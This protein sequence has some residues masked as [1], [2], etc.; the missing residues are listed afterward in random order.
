MS[1]KR[2]AA[3]LTAL[4]RENAKLKKELAALRGEDP[5]RKPPVATSADEAYVTA[6]L[7]GREHIISYEREGFEENTGSELATCLSE[8]I[9]DGRDFELTLKG[10]K[11]LDLEKTFRE[12]GI[13]PNSFVYARYT[14]PPLRWN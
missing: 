3:S 13:E 5:D 7:E 1:K 11:K 4:E 8:A 9:R 14:S 6:L 2:P 12:N 10:G